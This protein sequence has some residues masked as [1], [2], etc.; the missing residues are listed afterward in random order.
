[1]AG[2]S[3]RVPGKGEGAWPE[4]GAR[5]VTENEANFRAIFIHTVAQRIANDFYD[6][7]LMTDFAGDAANPLTR[8]QVTD[9]FTRYTDGALS[10]RLAQALVAFIL[11]GSRTEPARKCLSLMG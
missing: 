5:H 9:K 4:S 7:E 3:S 10:Q 2:C 6:Y 1:M 11:N 8:D